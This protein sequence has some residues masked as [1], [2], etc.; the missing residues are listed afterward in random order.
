MT[1][2]P[3]DVREDQGKCLLGPGAS[4]EWSASWSKGPLSV[5]L[6][7][8]VGKKR[9]NNEDSCMFFAPEPDTLERRGYLLAVADGMGGA[10]AGERASRLCLEQLADWFYSPRVKGLVPHALRY[11][12]HMANEA[13]FTEATA[14][15]EFEGMGTT[16]SAI[17]LFGNWAYL[18]Q[19]GDSRIYLHRPEKGFF[20]MT[21]DHSLVAEQLRSGLINENEAK[22]HLLKNLIT[23]A[24]GIKDSVEA[25]FFAVEL[26]RGDTVLLCSDGLS[27]M[28]PDE[29]L[30]AALALEDL[31]EITARLLQ[32]ALD[33]GGTDNITFVLMRVTDNLP[34]SYYQQGADKVLFDSRGF[35]K[36]LRNWFPRS[37]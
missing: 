12:L 36:R 37:R 2:R 7:S 10:S 28:V 21:E 23:R 32:G 33:G 16:L 17:A 13:V 14:N 25:D 11:A 1:E 29:Q 5:H 8:H 26:H 34:E 6:V 35:F 30:E 3:D 20:Q 24:V 22:N 27:N 31:N 4:L 19:V 9:Q 18:A 15:P